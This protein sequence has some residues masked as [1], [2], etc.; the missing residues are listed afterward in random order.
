ML[1]ELSTPPPESLS[2][3][4]IRFIVTSADVGKKIPNLLVSLIYL[5][6]LLVVVRCVSLSECMN[7]E[8]KLTTNRM[9]GLLAVRYRRLPMRFYT[10]YHPFFSKSSSL[11]SF[12]PIDIRVLKGLQSCILNLF[13]ISKMYF[14]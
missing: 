7:L 13:K 3:Y 4:P 8:S 1:L 11:P 6:T 9:S 10:Y 12:T 14:F 5:N 2:E